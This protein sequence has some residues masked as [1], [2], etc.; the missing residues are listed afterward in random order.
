MAM[1]KLNVY[2]FYS[3]CQADVYW[4]QLLQLKSVQARLRR[5]SILSRIV[6]S[7]NIMPANRKA[8]RNPSQTKAKSPNQDLVTGV[9]RVIGRFNTLGE[10]SK[11]VGCSVPTLS[12]WRKGE[13]Q[14]SLKDAISMG[15]LD[16]DAGQ[17]DYERVVSWL[18]LC[19]HG[20]RL[21]D[22]N[23]VLADEIR[24]RTSLGARLDE[25]LMNLRSV[26]GVKGKAV[27]QKDFRL[28]LSC[29]LG[30][31]RLREDIDDWK[32]K[33]NGAGTMAYIWRW[34]DNTCKR[35]QTDALK[36]FVQSLI[37]QPPHEITRTWTPPPSNS[38][39]G[40]TI[41]LQI[42]L[43]GNALTTAINQ[44]TTAVADF[45]DDVRLN[46]EER[47]RFNIFTTTESYRHPADCCVFASPAPG[48]TFAVLVS[49]YSDLVKEMEKSN[50]PEIKSNPY[51]WSGQI[52]HLNDPSVVA[53]DYLSEC[54]LQ[55]KN[56][57]LT[58]QNRWKQFV[59]SQ[60]SAT[61]RQ[62][63]SSAT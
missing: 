21:D 42:N 52:I 53:D 23:L 6:K 60:Q 5:E 30:Q 37:Q 35:F 1:S 2:V 29:Y 4:K 63:S 32:K 10:L 40:V 58:H 51:A 7:L 27:E 31:S 54:C 11:I 57:S 47:S 26:A 49:E 14:L 22:P 13:T 18:K 62:K 61:R 56:G 43:K 44:L 38:Q 46:K 9:E 34:H 19:G 45:L 39:I 17:S 33:S 36:L 8:A 3:E 15:L 28:A 59:P 41:Y 20:S 48:K 25:A 50:D 55:L 12:A 16:T 24:K